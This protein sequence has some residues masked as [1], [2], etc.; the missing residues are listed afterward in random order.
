[1]AYYSRRER[2]F[3]DWVAGRRDLDV[4]HFQEYTPWLAPGHCRTLRRRGLSLAF[5]VHNV[6]IHYYHNY[7]FKL[8][9]D[10]TLRTAWRE[11]DALLVHSQGLR[12]ALADFLG[13]GHPPIH[14]TA[15]GVWRNHEPAAPET[16]EGAG[17]R[18]RLLFFGVIRPN[19]GLHVLLRALERLPN[20]DLTV[21]GAAEEDGYH[22]Q[23]RKLARQF[24]PGRVELIDRYVAES[25]LPAFFER[26]RLVILP[27][28]FFAAQS[29]VLHQALA[30]GRP[31]VATDV[32]AMGECVKQWGIGPVVPAND[33]RA[34][35]E[36]IQRALEPTTYREALDAIARVRDEL[37]WGRMADA[38]IDVYHSI[39]A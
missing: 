20:C 10:S 7:A 34:L 24:P 1:M 3:L 19:K 30:F 16:G 31:V 37:T 9:R 39:T 23:V 29:G 22:E 17:E 36:G 14:V 25:E 21:A 5:T 27:Y 2:V 12:D 11:C 33:E 15:H 32:G 38:T 4:I 8:L 26:S 28:T 35:A 13:P 6:H 18:A